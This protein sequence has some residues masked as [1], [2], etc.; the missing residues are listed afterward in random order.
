MYALAEPPQLTFPQRHRRPAPDHDRRPR[1]VQRPRAGRRPV[2]PGTFFRRRV[3]AVALAVVVAAAVTAAAGAGP[4]GEQLVAMAALFG[5]IV[6][7]VALWRWDQHP[8][9]GVRSQYARPGALSAVQ[10]RRHESD[11]LAAV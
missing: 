3:I 11:R 6:A 7:A 2:T 9:T 10:R 5:S 8:T 1:R 4:F